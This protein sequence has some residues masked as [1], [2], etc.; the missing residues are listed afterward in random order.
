[1]I[2]GLAQVFAAQ[3]NARREAWHIFMHPPFACD[4]LQLHRHAVGTARRSIPGV[5]AAE[6]ITKVNARPN[7][8][9]QRRKK[10][11]E[12]AKVILPNMKAIVMST[13][14]KNR[15]TTQ[16]NNFVTRVLELAHSGRNGSQSRNGVVVV[17]M[18]LWLGCRGELAS[19]RQYH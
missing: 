3:R 4:S 16:L 17:P 6:F 19:A 1:L 18:V 15:W 9:A 14:Q 5:L 11:A 12:A 2:R 10:G 13:E 7:V 8:G